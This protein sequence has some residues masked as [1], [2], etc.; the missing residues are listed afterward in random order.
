MEN[1]TYILIAGG[2]VL[3]LTF[4]GMRKAQ[5]STPRRVLAIGDSLTAN[6]MYCTTLSKKLPKG[7]QVTCSGL[8]GQGTGAI[9]SNLQKEYSPV[10]LSQF[11]DIVV[12]AGVND[13][14]S[15]RSMKTI[16]SNLEGIYGYA[17]QAGVRVIG[18]ELTPW[19]GHIKGQHLVAKTD[20]LND[21][22]T[23]HPDLSAK[24]TT[25]DL[26]DFQGNL[27]SIYATGDG[28]HL[29][30]AGGAKLAELVYEQGLR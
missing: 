28:L 1:S 27:Q 3:A 22:L 13:L 5:A 7:N 12:L 25:R 17:R 6:K 16:K 8:V 9:L 24:V 20:E 4:L 21:W 18:V 29:N 2:T 26:G 14:A 19:N 15:G 30:S 10:A 23:G 11:T